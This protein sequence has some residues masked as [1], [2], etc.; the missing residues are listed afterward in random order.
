MDKISVDEQVK[1]V[2]RPSRSKEKNDYQ[3]NERKRKQRA[4]FEV[5]SIKRKRE[6][7]ER[8]L[9]VLYL[10]SKVTSSPTLLLPFRAV[11]GPYCWASSNG[12]AGPPGYP[13]DELCSASYFDASSPRR[14]FY[15]VSVSLAAY[16]CYTEKTTREESRKQAGPSES[17]DTGWKHFGLAQRRVCGLEEGM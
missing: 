9:A 15:T 13:L 2:R 1:R 17:Q 5:E 3:S 4:S 12:L 7:N 6:S 8:Y 10:S 11:F 14:S 16:C